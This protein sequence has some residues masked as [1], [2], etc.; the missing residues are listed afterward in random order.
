M[1]EILAN[2]VQLLCHFFEKDNIFAVHYFLYPISQK[3]KKEGQTHFCGNFVKLFDG[4]MRLM[5]VE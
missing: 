1:Y 4:L 5:D 2:L 3:Q